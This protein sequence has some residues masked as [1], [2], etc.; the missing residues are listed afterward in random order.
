MRLNHPETT[1]PVMVCGK[2]VFHEISSLCQKGWGLL[3]HG[4]PAMNL[5]IYKKQRRISS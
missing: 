5:F 1:P 2:T 4:I 3:L